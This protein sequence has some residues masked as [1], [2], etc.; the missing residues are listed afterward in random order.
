MIKKAFYIVNILFLILFTVSII[1]RIYIILFLEIVLCGILNYFLFY[2]KYQIKSIQL[3]L[4]TEELKPELKEGI[5]ASIIHLI[6]KRLTNNNFLLESMKDEKLTQHTMVTDA[7]HQIKTPLSSLK[8]STE[9]INEEEVLKETIIH[10]INRLEVYIN[11]LVKFSKIENDLIK[12]NIENTSIIP[13]I[14]NAVNSNFLRANNK[15]MTIEVSEKEMIINHDSFYTSEVISNI[16]DNAIKYGSD[17]SVI[18]IDA[19]DT[20]STY[21]I[22]I[23]NS[24]NS[25]NKDD[26]PYIFDRFYRGKNSENDNG[27]GVG[28]YLCR[29]I[30]RFQN[31]TIKV[32]C[33]N[34]EVT[35]SCVFFKV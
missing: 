31:G 14:I 15:G 28:L 20:A 11:A 30:M 33:K 29:E 3:Y 7:C 19:E 26:L 2:L 18:S 23:T 34:N 8:L 12:I 27:I 6:D 5:F 16:L 24:G 25:I 13:T 21:Q 17:D 4:Q 22:H 10:D 1:E 35:F 32:K 9:L